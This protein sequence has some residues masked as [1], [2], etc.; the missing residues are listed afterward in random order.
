MGFGH[1]PSGGGHGFQ[2]RRQPAGPQARLDNGPECRRQIGRLLGDH[3][4]QG[5]AAAGPFG[6]GRGQPSQAAGQIAAQF[7]Q[8]LLQRHAGADQA[9]ISAESAVRSSSVMAVVMGDEICFQEPILMRRA[10]L[11]NVGRRR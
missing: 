9:P 4:G 6:Q 11:A 8:P 1:S 7:R 10:A 5:L 2:G 3:V